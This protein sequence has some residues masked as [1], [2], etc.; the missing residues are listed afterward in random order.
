MIKEQDRIYSI[1]KKYFLKLNDNQP[2]GT[3]SAKALNAKMAEVITNYSTSNEDIKNTTKL[4]EKAE[5]S[6]IK[7]GILKIEK[8]ALTYS[9]APEETKASR[10]AKT[11]ETT[12]SVWTDEQKAENESCLSHLIFGIDTAN[13]LHHEHKT[14]DEPILY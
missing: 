10:F 8:D 4:I 12:V 6:L 3:L 13:V 1:L 2:N 7:D 14:G 11:S 5:K 9:S